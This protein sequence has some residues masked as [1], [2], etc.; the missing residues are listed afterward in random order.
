[1]APLLSLGLKIGMGYAV[2]QKLMLKTMAWRT[3][4]KQLPPVRVGMGAAPAPPQPTPPDASVSYNWANGVQYAKNAI[5]YV[6]RKDLANALKNLQ[7]AY[8]AAG[9]SNVNLNAVLES[10]PLNSL[11]GVSLAADYLLKMAGAKLPGAQTATTQLRK[12]QFQPG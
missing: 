12:I 11:S 7:T 2:G 6:S 8:K 9:A 3:P 4:P 1:M 5:V 10:T